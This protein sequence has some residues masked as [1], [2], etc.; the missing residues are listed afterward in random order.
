MNM[1]TNKKDLIINNKKQ[2][3]KVLKKY[4]KK[5]YKYNIIINIEDEDLTNCIKAT[6]ID[7]K[8]KRNEFIYDVMCNILDKKWNSNIPCNFCNNRCIASR[9]NFMD[10]EYDGCCYS[11]ERKRFGKVL[12]EKFIHLQNDKTCDTKNISCKLFTCD[13]LKKNKIFN[14]NYDDYLLLRLFFNKKEKLI[15]KYNFFKTKEEVLRKLNE[16]NLKPYIL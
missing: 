5:P 10:K 1:Q 6:N 12:K 11:F 3:Y 15:I 14:T 13:Y 8:N 16:K 2:G 7:D 4:I 9:N